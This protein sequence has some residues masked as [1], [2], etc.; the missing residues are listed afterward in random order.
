MNN[1][2]NKVVGQISD[3]FGYKESEVKLI[4]DTFLES[5]AETLNEGGL[6]SIHNF[7]SFSVRKRAARAG[8][9][10]HTKEKIIIPEKVSPF[11]V[12]SNQLKE[13]IRAC[14]KPKDV[15]FKKQR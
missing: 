13:G 9:N 12:A 14:L 15:K 2:F 10:V 7:G 5:I 11:F 1:S 6:F 4:L 8:L 3:D